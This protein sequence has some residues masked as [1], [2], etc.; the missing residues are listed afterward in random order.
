MSKKINRHILKSLRN[1]L[2]NGMQHYLT[3]SKWKFIIDKTQLT[4]QCCGIHNYQDWYSI[5]WLNKYQVDAKASLV[6]R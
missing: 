6:Q 4:Q 1:S 2:E 3:Q 5:S